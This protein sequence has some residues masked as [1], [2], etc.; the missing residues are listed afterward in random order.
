MNQNMAAS[1]INMY[2]YYVSVKIFYINVEF[3]KVHGKW[4]YAEN[5]K[6]KLL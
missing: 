5:H 2:K 4:I 1:L 3:L 6:I